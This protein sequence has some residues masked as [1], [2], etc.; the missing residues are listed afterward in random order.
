[1]I[2]DKLLMEAEPDGFVLDACGGGKAVIILCLCQARLPRKSN[3]KKIWAN[4]LVRPYVR[5]QSISLL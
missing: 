1:M 2:N 4:T 5:N 3:Y